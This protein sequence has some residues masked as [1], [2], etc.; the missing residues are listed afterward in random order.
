MAN[1][2]YDEGREAIAKATI[3]LDTATIDLVAVSS[4][5]TFAAGHSSADLAGIL[6]TDAALTGQTVSS[7]GW[8][9]TDAAVFTGVAVGEDPAGFVLRVQGGVLLAFYDTLNNDQPVDITGDGT[10]LTIN[11]PTSGWFRV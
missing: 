9:T 1:A 8:F 11:P 6:D 7:T 3:D 2:K 4:A 5:Y 10:T